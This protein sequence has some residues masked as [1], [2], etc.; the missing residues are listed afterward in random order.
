MYK[1]EATKRGKYNNINIG[2]RYFLFKKQALQC[3]KMFLE[4]EAEPTIT[5]FTR[6]YFG[7]YAWSDEKF[8]DTIINLRLK[9][10]EKK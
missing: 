10:L 7:V 6:L 9:M 1:V 3:Y 4:E 8:I 5:K 2:A